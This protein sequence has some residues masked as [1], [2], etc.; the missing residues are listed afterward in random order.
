MYLYSVRIL[1]KLD[2]TTE[3]PGL[4]SPSQKREKEYGQERSLDGIDLYISF[5]FILYLISS[6]FSQLD[7]MSYES[8]ESFALTAGHIRM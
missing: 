3:R 6:L 5:S 1:R 4:V 8:Y 2:T 7:H